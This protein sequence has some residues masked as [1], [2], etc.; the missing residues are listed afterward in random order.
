M[1]SP[2]YIELSLIFFCYWRG[3]IKYYRKGCLGDANLRIHMDI[4]YLSIKNIKFLYFENRIFI[5][6]CSILLWMRLILC[7]LSHICTVGEYTLLE[8]EITNS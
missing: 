8:L 3:G 1:L 5:G 7:L 2:Q 6:S 4:K